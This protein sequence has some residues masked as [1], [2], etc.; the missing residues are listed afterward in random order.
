MYFSIAVLLRRRGNVS[1]FVYLHFL[2]YCFCFVATA[3]SAS[4]VTEASMFLAE[5]VHEF[6]EKFSLKSLYCFQKEIHMSIW[7]IV[8]IG[9]SLIF[10]VMGT[11]FTY[12]IL[13]NG[14]ET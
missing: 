8:P 12:V 14:F 13:F 11:I 2:N 7:K 1:P 6:P 9:R 3:M 4:G 5:K 10:G